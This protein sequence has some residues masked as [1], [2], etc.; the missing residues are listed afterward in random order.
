MAP[1]QRIGRQ[2]YAGA[3]LLAVAIDHIAQ[4]TSDPKNRRRHNPR[5]VGMIASALG[6]VGA[7]RSIVIDEGGVVL[8]G[9]ATLEAAAQAG[10]ERVRVV[11]ADGEEII[12]VRRSNLSDEQKRRLALFDNRTAE[13]AEWDLDQLLEDVNDGASFEGM[14]TGA[15]LDALLAELRTTEPAADPG[16]QVDRAEE[17]RD[18]WQTA[19][20]DLWLIGPHRL[21]C[22]DATI[23]E[24]VARLMDGAR[25]ELTFTDPPYNVGKDYGTSVD[26]AR[27]DYAEF[28]LRWFGLC[29]SACIVFTPGTVNLSLWCSISPPKWVCAWR[30]VNQVSPSALNGWNTWEPLLVYGK[31]T[32]PVGHDSWDIP[33]AHADVDHP[34]PKS[35]DPWRTFLEAFSTDGARVYDPFVGSGTTHVVAEQTGRI[36]YGLELEPKYVAVCLERLAGMGL[37]PRR[38]D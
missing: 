31:H 25:A 19:R 33:V 28:S 9:N 10:I 38:A 36:A 21:L 20:G 37:E 18:K 13:L 34:V 32:K 4:L 24:D 12:A 6:E 27:Q 3:F 2:A 8:A 22:G 17:L 14:F 16:A 11:D 15:E 7:A 30:K 26:D 5:N 29:P 35:V 1:P 23:A